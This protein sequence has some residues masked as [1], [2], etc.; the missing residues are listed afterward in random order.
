QARVERKAF[1][2]E[3]N[4]RLQARLQRQAPVALGNVR[5]ARGLAGNAGGERGLRGTFAYDVTLLVEEHVARRR[6]RRDLACIDHDLE[7]VRGSMQQPKATATQTGA[8]RLDDR[9][10]GA[11]R[12]R[13]VEGVAALLQDL[14]PGSS[15]ELMRARD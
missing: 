1:A 11:D 6:E 10:C 7:T 2:R 8:A 9:E 4:R 13:G 14:E 3:T 12:H 5:E 15:C